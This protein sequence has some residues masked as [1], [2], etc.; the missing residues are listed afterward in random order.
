MA[1]PENCKD[2]K[3]TGGTFDMFD[4]KLGNCIFYLG[5][6]PRQLLGFTPEAPDFLDTS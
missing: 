4:A 6:R 3:L 2:Q 1:E 5:A